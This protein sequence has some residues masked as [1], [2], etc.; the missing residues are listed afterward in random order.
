MKIDQGIKSN[1]HVKN[2]P[3]W[4]LA[5]KLNPKAGK[6]GHVYLSWSRASFDQKK[7]SFFGIGKG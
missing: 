6:D 7:L 1:A 5:D 3:T 4:Y 2:H